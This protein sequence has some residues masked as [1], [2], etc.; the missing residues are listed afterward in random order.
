MSDK[1]ELSGPDLSGGVAPA[2]IA[3]GAMLLGHV[4]EEPVILARRG[5]EFFA[6]SALCTHYQG[7]LAEGI[8]VEDT[9]RCPFASC[10]FQ[11]AHRR[12]AARAG[13]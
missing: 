11:P 8:L 1:Q 12:S 3:D 13:A 5:E 6:I 7:P 9:V 10:L 4:G 2:A